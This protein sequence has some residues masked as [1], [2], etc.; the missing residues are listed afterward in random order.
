MV[1]SQRLELYNQVLVLRSIQQFI[2]LLRPYYYKC[3][4]TR[5]GEGDEGIELPHLLSSFPQPC[6]VSEG[7][8]DRDANVKA[9]PVSG[10]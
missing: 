9:M 10:C 7:I 8:E 5:C 4:F 6:A 2:R 3:T 1:S